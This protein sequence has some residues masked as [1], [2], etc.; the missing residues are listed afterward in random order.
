M[1]IYG[2]IK[3]RKEIKLRKVAGA[4]GFEPRNDGIKNR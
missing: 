1:C 3:R 2:R 4:L